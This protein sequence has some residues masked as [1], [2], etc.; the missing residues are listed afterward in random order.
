MADDRDAAADCPDPSPPAPPVGASTRRRGRRRGWFATAL[1][2]L[3]VSLTGR[4]ALRSDPAGPRTLRAHPSP[5]TRTLEVGLLDGTRLSITV[6][7]SVGAA[8]AGVTPRDFERHGSVYVEPGS[9]RG[10][11]LDVTFDSI[12]SLMVGAQPLSVPPSSTVSA[13]LL[14]R[15]TR[16]LGF[17]FGSWAVIASGD[18]LTDAD[19]DL[20][21]TGM[22]FVGTPDGF[23]EYRGSLPLS[24]VDGPVATLSAN[25]VELSALVRDCRP[26]GKPT[27]PG[28]TVEDAGSPGTGTVT[29]LC[30]PVNR[31][32]IQLRTAASLSGED[33][34]GVKVEVLSAGS[35]LAAVRPGLTVAPPAP[36]TPKPTSLEPADSR[37]P[38]A[39]VCARADGDVGNVRFGAADLV[40]QPR[41]LLLR[42]DQRLSVTNVSDGALRVTLGLAYGASVGPGETHVFDAP[43]GEYLAPG[44]H[45][46]MASSF[47]ADIWVD[48]VC[49]GPQ[50]SPP[51]ST[52]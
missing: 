25:G 9:E 42:G 6:P 31:I 38:A 50:G 33:V 19:I 40:P 34:D 44:V 4:T 30:D 17:Q 39:G 49:T 32:A 24:I 12:G 46:L 47:A 36:S 13:A 43:L 3:M 15:A 37:S 18:T 29:S 35:F 5:S 2:L 20:L 45:R 51:C 26:L 11:R 23:G 48:A 22:A 16:R 21:L 8:F 28:M 52:P 27:K 41:C 10:W 1:L 7:E 14:D